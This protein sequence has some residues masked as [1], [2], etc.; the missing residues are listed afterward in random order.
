VRN[1]QR[2]PADDRAPRRLEELVYE[3]VLADPLLNAA[4]AE[5]RDPERF[6][7]FVAHYLDAL[8]EAGLPGDEPFREAV[9]S[10]ATGST[11]PDRRG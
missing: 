2:R 4:R 11:V 9:R 10:V 7:R 8:H 1:P 5:R 3:T 6:T